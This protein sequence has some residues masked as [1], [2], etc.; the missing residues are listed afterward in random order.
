MSQTKSRSCSISTTHIWCSFAS[1][2]NVT[3]ISVRSG[4]VRPAVG[5][6]S[7]TMLGSSASTMASSS[8][9][10]C[11][12]D[13]RRHGVPRIRSR[14]VVRTI[15]SDAFG[16]ETV[17]VRDQRRAFTR[18]DRATASASST[19]RSSNTLAVWN[20]RPMPSRTHSKGGRRPMSRSLSAMVPALRS[21][22]SLMQRIKVVLPAPLGPTSDNSS[23][24]RASKLTSRSTVRLPKRR[25]T[26]DSFR[27]SRPRPSRPAR[28]SAVAQ[29]SDPPVAG[30]RRRRP[31]SPGSR[32]RGM[33][34]ITNTK[35][36]PS[37]SFH[38]NG[39]SPLR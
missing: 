21:L 6:S 1:V 35:A 22:P 39:R 14:P 7:S 12:C 29:A 34:T 8:A 4:L 16:S 38:T 30:A 10:F 27:A 18:R 19:V 23:P 2:C 24:W 33:T 13:S 28:G 17:E 31:V 36:M 3:P 32:P 25:T 9:C 15:D 5:S 20:F 37:S 26:P 11:P